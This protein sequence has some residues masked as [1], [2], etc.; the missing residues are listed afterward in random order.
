MYR[1]FDVSDLDKDSME[2]YAFLYSSAKTTFDIDPI[3]ADEKTQKKIRK[4]TRK[5]YL[6][7]FDSENKPS[8]YTA[9][10]KSNNEFFEFLSYCNE[11]VLAEAEESRTRFERSVSDFS[12]D[13]ANVFYRFFEES[14]CCECITKSDGEL[15]LLS[16]DFDS[17]EETLVLHL[18]RDIDIAGFDYLSFADARILKERD[19]Y[20]LECTGECEATSDS[21]L[22]NICFD[23]A[24]CIK[25]FFR[26]EF[27]D[28]VQSPWHMLSYLA[29][30]ILDN[31][32]RRNSCNDREAE[33]LP[34]L[35][36]LTLLH[37]F[38]RENK[39]HSDEI[40]FGLLKCYSAKYG[41]SHLSPL[42]DI[43]AKKLN[44][45]SDT[46]MSFYRLDEELNKSK[47]EEMWRELYDL[48]TNSQAEYIRK[49]EALHCTEF[50]ELRA[51]VEKSFHALGYS[52]EYPTFYKK[53]K[54]G[55]IR[56]V[57]SYGMSYFIGTEKNVEYRVECLEK[58]IGNELVITFLCGTA[59]LKKGENICDI[60]SCCFNV[61]GRRLFKSF[62]CNNQKVDLSVLI[63]TKKAECLSLSK[64]ERKEFT[65]V[66]SAEPFSRLTFITEFLF[67]GALFAI[68]I[69]LMVVVIVSSVTALL[70][71]VG[72]IPEALSQMPWLMIFLISFIGFGGDM[73]ICDFF[74][75]RK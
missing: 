28:F 59:L 67:C 49:S 15:H 16:D 4:H 27:T 1:S 56:L 21:T 64:E 63:A 45:A 22:L 10:S 72:D 47:C 32:E 61:G 5:E 30:D 39:F 18:T 40:D 68:L 44:N 74:A 31:I 14:G 73:A 46:Y 75:K 29:Y 62:E 13:V 20:I 69:M 11:Y 51:N 57:E 36:E 26:V 17:Y 54:I 7:Y 70:F 48:I 58:V 33:I 6:R 65:D 52:G 24:K 34:L 25:T 43:A 2:Y 8:E 41:L 38:V 3:T 12:P 50:N 42:F 35:R 23:T 71:D 9:D 19:R 55:K 66:F 60:Y 37:P 53:G